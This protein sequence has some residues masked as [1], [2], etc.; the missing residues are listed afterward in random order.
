LRRVAGVVA[1][2]VLCAAPAAHARDA[3]VVANAE[4]GTV[5]VVDARTFRVLRE[6]DV[7]PD[8]PRAE[9][10]QDDPAQ[11][12]I[13]QQIV[14]AAGGA[15]Y[16]QD[17][18]VSPD[19]RTLYVSRGHRGD[20]AAFDI[21]S[22]KLRWKVPIPGLRSDH[23]TISEDG[24]RL[25]VS[26]LTED[27][28]E[29]V[30]TERRAIVASFPAGQWPHDNH[31]SHDGRRLYN[32]S[33]G[34]VVAPREAREAPPAQPYRL[35]VVDADTLAPLGSHVFE[36]GVRPYAITHDETRMYAQ[37]S[38]FHG[39]VEYGLRQGRVLRSLD[40]PV[41]PGV[42]EEDYDFE[43]P[44]HG[45]AL[46]PDES[47]LCLAGRAS[48]YVALVATSTLAPLAIIDVDDAPGWAAIAPDGR[49]CFVANTRADTLSVVSLAERRE[50]ARIPLGDGP[51]Q[52]EPAR[53]PDDVACGARGCEPE[54]RLVAS[55]RR[56]AP[57]REPRRRARRGPPRDVPPRRRGRAGR[58][59]A[60]R[61]DVRPPH[62]GA[63]QGTPPARDRQTGRRARE[64][65]AIGAVRGLPLSRRRAS[66]P[67]SRAPAWQAARAISA[68][69]YSR[70]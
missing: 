17:V 30:D 60:V 37:L 49:H 65:E 64:G 50:V 14:E 10:G 43:A 36:R 57:A 46:T 58:P 11:A 56:G 12:L 38:E 47:T 19:G 24:R 20:V 16:A 34:N 31:L 68:G 23:M 63:P 33:I 52:I 41:D 9:A 39:V 3:M 22:G 4:G 40:L 66:A 15:N 55:C 5:S 54:L 21:A 35:T 44:H 53:L 18:D 45:L 42:T 2:L 67:A 61:P 70:A 48:D 29:V 1:L 28:V 26:A 69:I 59:C 27:E 62:N 32:G 51:K 6:I 8:G 7:L 25:Y 13:G